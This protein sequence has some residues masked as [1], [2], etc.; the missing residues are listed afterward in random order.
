MNFH[1]IE[2]GSTV[3]GDG[4]R[5]VLWVSGC[6]H[7]C[8]GCQNPETWDENSG[9]PFTDEYKYKLFASVYDE[10]VSGITLSGGDPLY[11]NNRKD[12]FSLIREFKHYF[13]NKTV[14]L[15]TGYEWEDILNME[16]F[17]FNDVDIVVCGKFDIDKKDPNYHWAGS[18][19]QR[20]INVPLYMAGY[21]RL[22]VDR[23][24]KVN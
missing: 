10:F 5:T 22:I 21:P 1:Y 24:T 17:P 4:V 6:N 11:P 13:P 20:V 23:F 7:R 19:N 14:W 2:I 18:T 15:Y 12:V 3:N 8:K 9:I 16:D